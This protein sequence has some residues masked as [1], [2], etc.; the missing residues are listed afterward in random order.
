MKRCLDQKGKP[1]P[2]CGHET[3]GCLSQ[4]VAHT[5]F[6][7]QMVAGLLSRAHFRWALGGEVLFQTDS[8][9]CFIQSG[10][11]SRHRVRPR[12]LRWGSLRP[13]GSWG[14]TSHWRPPCTPQTPYTEWK[15]RSASQRSPCG[16]LGYVCTVLHSKPNRLS[17]CLRGS[18]YTWISS[19][20]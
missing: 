1:H 16:T 18:T 9:S 14:R 5:T 15:T 7:R 13:W 11:G 4:A 2:S 3:S 6:L 8:V 20:L 10:E 17:S 19:F 12:A